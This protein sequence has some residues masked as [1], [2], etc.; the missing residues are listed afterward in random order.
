[1]KNITYYKNFIL[2]DTNKYRYC[3][4]F[5]NLI[6]SPVLVI[7]PTINCDRLIVDCTLLSVQ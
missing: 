3:G 7:F 2:K 5:E 6:Y 1:M 4:H